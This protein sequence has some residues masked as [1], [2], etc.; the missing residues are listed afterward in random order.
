MHKRSPVKLIIILITVALVSACS[1]TPPKPVAELPESDSNP[2]DEVNK[3]ENEIT[4]AKQN[5][6]DILSPDM[7]ARAE[8]SYLKA[9]NE[10]EKK[11]D[12]SVVSEYTDTARKYLHNAEENAKVARTVLEQVIESRSK[13]RI[14]GA[15]K[16]E[17]DYQRVEDQFLIL[18]HAIEKNNIRYSQKNAPEVDNEYRK[19]ELRAIKIET[20]GEV[21]AILKKAKKDDITQYAPES[22]ALAKKLLNETDAFISE[23]PYAKEEMYKMAQNNLFMA[24]RALAIADQCKAIESMPPEEIAFYVE[25]TLGLITTKLGAPDM[26]DQKFYIQVDNIEESIQSFLDNNQFMA[27]KLKLKRAEMEALQAEDE[28]RIDELNQQIA[29][30]EG[31]TIEEQA[32]NE[33]LMAQQRSMEQKLAAARQFNQLFTEVQNYFDASEAEVYKKGNQLV[34]R[35]KGIQFPV[36]QAIIMPDNYLLLSKAQRAIR[37]FGEPS[38]VIEGHTDSTGTHELNKHLSQQRAESVREYLIAN[39]T[40]PAEKVIAV[41]Y[42]PERPLASN[43]TPEGR[44]INR[45]ID[46]IIV[47]ESLPE[48]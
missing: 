40:L 14:A 11:S 22:F 7:F 5:Q 16:L 38:V 19:L 42:G 30:L 27:E 23:N 17:K 21:R 41:G 36:G 26:R 35:L 20:I 31:K 1:T 4:V 44:A 10:A 48:E 13:A 46:M 3:I 28:K 32:A 37:T 25:D 33:R 39:Q 8:N 2:I 47:P 43:S 29:F 34:I 18:T 12:I 24:R 15:T 6:I 9:K 45:R